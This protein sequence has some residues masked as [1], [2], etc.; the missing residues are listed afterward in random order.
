MTCLDV[1]DVTL[2]DWCVTNGIRADPHYFT[3]AYESVEKDTVVYGSVTWVHTYD[4]QVMWEGHGMIPM[5][6][7]R[8]MVH[9]CQYWMYGRD[10]EGMLLA[11]GLPTGT[12]VF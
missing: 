1:R 2:S 3:G 9:V 5:L 11:W 4:A 7:T 12:S 6:L 8:H 10:Q